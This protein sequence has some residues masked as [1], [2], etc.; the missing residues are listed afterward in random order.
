MQRV[1][2]ELKISSEDVYKKLETLKTP[3]DQLKYLFTLFD[4]VKFEGA[5]VRGKNNTVAACLR[6]KGNILYGRG[7]KESFLF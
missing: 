6:K 2:K 3:E 7:G 4:K 1:C 5:Y